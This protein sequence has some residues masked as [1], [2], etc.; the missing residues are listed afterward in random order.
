MYRLIATYKIE[1]P[2][3]LR[4]RRSKDDPL[5]YNAVIEEFDVEVALV[6]DG[7]SEYKEKDDLHFTRTVTQIEISI[8]RDEDSAP[9]DV[10]ASERGARDFRNRAPWFHQ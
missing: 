5:R 7:D 1:L 9:P 6:C 10:I 8:S 2:H 3:P 4:I